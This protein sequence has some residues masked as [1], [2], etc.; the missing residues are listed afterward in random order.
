MDEEE[1][2]ARA[3]LSR[4]EADMVRRFAELQRPV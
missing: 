2:Q 4:L 3:A 1:R